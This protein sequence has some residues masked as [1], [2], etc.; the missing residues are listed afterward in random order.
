MADEIFR[1]SV[2]I[3]RPASEAP[4]RVASPMVV[5]ARRSVFTL[6]RVA[7]AASMLMVAGISFEVGK[8]RESAPV[9]E[10]A[11]RS[12]RLPGTAVPMRAVP[13]VVDAATD[14]FVS[15]PA[16][17]ARQRPSGGPRSEAEIAVAG[18]SDTAAPAVAVVDVAID[19][20]A[21]RRAQV[22]RDA[23]ADRKSVV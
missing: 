2:R 23:E 16:P 20:A 22:S 9:L 12:A 7:V 18:R 17:S 14:S 11:P 5:T 3:E 15:A 13:S 6:R 21:Q 1:R 19:T 8:R 4:S 10:S